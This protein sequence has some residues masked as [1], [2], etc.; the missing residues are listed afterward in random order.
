MLI[1]NIIY[2]ATKKEISLWKLSKEA[3]ISEST[4]RSLKK[5]RFDTLNIDYVARLAKVLGITIDELYY[6]SNIPK[7]DMNIEF[8]AI[9][10]EDRKGKKNE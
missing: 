5:G 6:G 9:C 1:D 3:D 10:P 8:G 4:L 7:L 2:Y